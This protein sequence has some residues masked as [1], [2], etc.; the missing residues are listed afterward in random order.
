VTQDIILIAARESLPRLYTDFF[1]HCS[2]LPDIHLL[3]GRTVDHVEDTG[4]PDVETEEEGRLNQDSGLTPAAGLLGEWL[5]FYGPVTTDF[6]FQTL[7]LKPDQLKSLLDELLESQDIIQGR[8]IADEEVDQICDRENFEILLRLSRVSVDADFQT[9]DI[10]CFPLFLAHYQGLTRASNPDRQLMETLTPLLGWP[11]PAGLWETDIIPARYARYTTDGLDQLMQQ[12]E[13]C[14]IGQP[15]RK[16]LLSFEHELDLIREEILI[17]DGSPQTPDQTT[18]PGLDRLFP[19]PSG[20]YPF[21]VLQRT[22]G[23]NSRDLNQQL[24]AAVWQG[25]V[26][27]DGF[28]A[29]RHGLAH[30]FKMPDALSS[31]GHRR[32]RRPGPGRRAFER[33]QKS[34]P[35]G[36]WFRIIPPEEL[37]D[38]LELEECNKDRVRLL[39]D[40]Y[41]I[42]FR[43][44]LARELP[45]FQWSALFRSLRIMELSG[46]VITGHFFSHIPG[47]QFI[48][49]DALQALRESLPE[50][51]VFWLNAADPASLCGI[52]IDALRTALPR[53]I[54]GNH[55]VYHGFRPVVISRGNGRHL[56]IGV[57]ADAPDI[58][59]YFNFLNHM[60]SRPVAP[61][62]RI[63]IET[64]NEQ[65]ADETTPYLEPLKELFDVVP[66]PK[67]LTLYHRH[68]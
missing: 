7:A 40:R 57:P 67:G 15:G 47:L 13:L 43:E 3:S 39:L 60:L 2:P 6:I 30:Q 54:A 10:S 19:D 14:W 1:I 24:W 44:L 58:K 49:P 27:N 33:W 37:R 56:N 17:S 68:T 34:R 32:Y 48:A 64:I 16:V 41:G 51:A 36:N 55:L 31:T 50:N 61:V 9:L 52:G 35:P 63:I 38:G 62:S 20:R 65:P 23:L 12:D 22:T 53:R 21:G 59:T 45:Q 66:D 11:A 28:A 46:E 42:V 18:D 5:R 25:T 26:T 8:L 4:G 29:L